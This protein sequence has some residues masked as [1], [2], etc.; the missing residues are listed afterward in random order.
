VVDK[1]N[2]VM[3]IKNQKFSMNPPLGERAGGG[4]KG[5]ELGGMV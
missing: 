1:E 3:K 4:S 2:Y 5:T